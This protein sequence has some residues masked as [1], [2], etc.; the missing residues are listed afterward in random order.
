MPVSLALWHPVVFSFQ[1]DPR[2]GDIQRAAQC[3]QNVSGALVA[4][5]R[6]YLQ[7]LL[8]HP[9]SANMSNSHR[10]IFVWAYEHSPFIQCSPSLNRLL[11]NHNEL[12]DLC[13]PLFRCLTNKRLIT[14]P[15]CVYLPRHTSSSAFRMRPQVSGSPLTKHGHKC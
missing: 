4:V 10:H 13:S 6:S 1:S 7:T 8:M 5:E 14:K 12:S 15:L 3:L 2:V 9:G 11:G